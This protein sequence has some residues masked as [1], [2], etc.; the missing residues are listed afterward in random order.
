MREYWRNLIEGIRVMGFWRCMYA[1]NLYRPH[2][3]LIHKQGQHWF[4]IV[5]HLYPDGATY[6]RCDWCGKM[7]NHSKVQDGKDG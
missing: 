2:M 4:K 5:G 7:I 1:R 6:E 3:R